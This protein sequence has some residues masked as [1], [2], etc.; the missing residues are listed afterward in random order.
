[1]NLPTVLAEARW[2]T[3]P[4][5]MLWCCENFLTAQQQQFGIHARPQ[6]ALSLSKIRHGSTRV[7]AQQQQFGIHAHSMVSLSLKYGVGLL[8]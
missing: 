3:Y 4:D 6:H 7:V 2:L 5:P 8:E 1:M